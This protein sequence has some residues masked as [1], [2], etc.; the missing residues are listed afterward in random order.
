[1]TKSMY[2]FN[3]NYTLLGLD[4]LRPVYI[5]DHPRWRSPMSQY[6]NYILLW[7][8]KFGCPSTVYTSS[9]LRFSHSEKRPLRYINLLL[10]MRR[11]CQSFH[12]VDAMTDLAIF[13]I[14]VFFCEGYLTS[15][16]ACMDTAIH[17]SA[18][19]GY[20]LLVYILL[21]YILLVEY[22]P[23]LMIW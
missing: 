13:N 15:L 7:L 4:Q 8:R 17:Y 12:T 5:H 21:V 9:F 18:V 16:L 1:M 22:T 2:M 11:Y 19:E 20:I 3:L 6:H 23:C 14:T 10:L